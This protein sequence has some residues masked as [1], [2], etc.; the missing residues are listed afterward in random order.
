ME[1][2]FFFV[3]SPHPHPSP[4]ATSTEP[5]IWKIFTLL[6]IVLLHGS[7]HADFFLTKLLVIFCPWHILFQSTAS[8]NSLFTGMYILCAH[9]Q[10][11]TH[12][13]THTCMHACTRVWLVIES[14]S[15]I[16]GS[17][18]MEDH[19]GSLLEPS[20]DLCLHL[21]MYGGGGKCI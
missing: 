16:S 6:H 10:R 7:V 9:M 12:T 15:H 17:G 2:F 14:L 3:F 8:E 1:R 21:Q 18:E 11:H 20:N 4:S 5:V 13:H 19:G